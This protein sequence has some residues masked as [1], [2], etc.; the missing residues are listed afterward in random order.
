MVLYKYSK[1]KGKNKLLKRELKE[2]TLIAKI[3]LETRNW[4]LE[5]EIDG[6]CYKYEGYIINLDNG[7]RKSFEGTRIYG[8]YPDTS[9][10]GINEQLADEEREAIIEKIEQH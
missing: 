10:K 8:N 9:A 6:K 2:M 1:G 3:K 7:K 5:N 4:E